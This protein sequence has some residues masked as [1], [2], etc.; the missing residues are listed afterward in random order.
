MLCDILAALACSPTAAAAAADVHSFARHNLSSIHPAS[1]AQLETV[2]GLQRQQAGLLAAVQQLA[3]APSI[4][5]VAACCHEVHQRLPALALLPGPICQKVVAQLVQVAGR[6]AAAPAAAKLVASLLLRQD[7]SV[8]QAALEAA[9]QLDRSVATSLLCRQLVAGSLVLALGDAPPRQHLAASLLQAVA[10]A[11]PELCGKAFQPWEAWLHCHAG[12]AAE[13]Q[14]AAAVSQAVV[15]AKFSVW[16][17][18]LP[19]LL[20]LF[21]NNPAAASDAATELHSLLV[22]R[23]PAAAGAMLFCPLPFDGLLQPAGSSLSPAPSCGMGA[24]KGGAASAA[25]LFTAADVQSLLAVAGNASLPAELAAA[26]LCQLAHV[27]GDA[28][29][30]AIMGQEAGELRLVDELLR[31]E[32]ALLRPGRDSTSRVCW[33]V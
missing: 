12:Q 17:H 8:R 5:L 32:F 18:V 16:Q 7:A 3:V 11:A 14:A 10:A 4:A 27:A 13:G 6:H 1:A 15:S 28:R 25:K 29:F 23:R 33:C 24:G 9:G 2:S 21:H 19:L 20:T 30:A 31:V 22:Q 26:A